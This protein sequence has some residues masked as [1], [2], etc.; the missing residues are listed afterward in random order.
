MI[1]ISTGVVQNSVN[2]EILFGLNRIKLVDNRIYVNICKNIAV[3]NIYITRPYI[4][5][6]EN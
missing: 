4:A 6:E 3:Q 2:L 5:E 1:L